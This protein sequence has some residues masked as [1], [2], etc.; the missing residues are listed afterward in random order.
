[1]QEYKREKNTLEARVSD[2]AKRATYHDDHLRIVDAWWRQVRHFFVHSTPKLDA[3][4]LL[5]AT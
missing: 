2:M 5:L 1:M 4:V 3:Y